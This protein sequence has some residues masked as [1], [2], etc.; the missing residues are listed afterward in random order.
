VLCWLLNLLAAEILVHRSIINTRS[1][2]PA[3][4]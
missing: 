1:T 4:I 3:P 2:S